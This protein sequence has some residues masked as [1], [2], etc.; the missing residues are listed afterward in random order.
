MDKRYWD[1]E[2]YESAVREIRYRI[3]DPSALPRFSDPLT[4]PVITKL[5]DKQNVAVI[6]EDETLGLD[7]RQEQ[8]EGFFHATGDLTES[9]RV[10]DK[11]DKFI[12]PKELV[13]LI[14]FNLY[15]QLLYFKLGN[16]SI[17]KD[18]VN[19]ESSE[20]ARVVGRNAQIVVDNFEIYIKLLAKQGALDDAA[21][22][23]YAQIINDRYSELIETF[24]S[25]SY[26]GITASAE[27]VS[28]KVN[29]PA[30]ES[31]LKAFVEK[32]HNRNYGE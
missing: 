21:L 23:Q 13:E 7:F 19:P 2:D 26:A 6:L 32:A 11:Q 22:R 12:Y 18:A 30:L 31:A 4:G 14:D 25:S 24:P 9:Y 1:L 28:K 8:A 5:V 3:E 16:E 15:V 27:S 29:N 17:I 10:M 20:V